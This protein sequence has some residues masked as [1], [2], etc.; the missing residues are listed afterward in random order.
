MRFAPT[1]FIMIIIIFG[2]FVFSGNALALTYEG[3]I[4]G[5]DGAVIGPPSAPASVSAVASGYTSIDVS[6][7]AVAGASGYKV[8]RNA[9]DGNWDSAT[10]ATTTNA[11]FTS[12]ADTGLTSGTTYYYKVK[13]YNSSQSSDFSAAASA[14]TNAL[15]VPANL[16]ALVQSTSQINL[17][18]SAVSGVDGYKIYRNDSLI[19]T[20]AGLTYSDTALSAGT[21]YSYK[22]KSYTG[23]VE[24]ALSAAVAATTQNA[25]ASSGGGGGGSYTPSAPSSVSSNNTPLTLS[26]TQTGT[27]SYVFPD[28]SSAKVEVPSGAVGSATTFSAAQ[29][30]LTAAQTP[31]QTTGAFM[32]GGSVFNITAQD[33]GGNLVRNFSNQLA[34]TLAVPELPADTTDLAVYYFNDATGEWV[35]VAGASFNTTT[36]TATF[37]VNHLTIF[38]IFKVAGTPAA[39]ATDSIPSG[40][41]LGE[42]IT[43]AVGSSIAEYVAAQKRL[44]KAIDKK[45]T[46]RLSGRILL[47]AQDKGEA[48]YVEPVSQ[49][50]YYLADGARAYGALRKFGLG[51]TNK[52]LA[53]IPVGIEKRFLDTDT[54]GD[55]LADKLE[56]GLGTDI[57]N[58]D[59]DSDGVSDYDEVIKNRT[60]PLGSGKLSYDNKLLNRLK[61]R[62]VLQVESRG[63]AWYINPV[64]G[65]RYYLKDGNAAY[66]IMRFL[67]LGITNSDIQKIGIGDL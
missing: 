63:E 45:L 29:G 19:A 43:G 6:W 7:N 33:A 10:L 46:K 14:A 38:A 25:S 40:Q 59:T 16:A 17:S 56:E 57:N 18:W 27:V 3:T 60:N 23:S 24:S 15:G 1:F 28:S 61:G 54:D 64:D 5:G 51:I 47:Q 49:V 35:E 22:V 62:I 41:V 50:R 12:Y 52:D 55:G 67:S 30:T 20:Q 8:Y 42:K 39:I 48:W 21:S 53:K 11:S 13:A 32:V 9:T 66:Q 26:S 36:K 65:K 2:G 31:A 4:G 44:L 34:I 58:T 37:S